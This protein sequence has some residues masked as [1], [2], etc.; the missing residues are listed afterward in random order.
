VYVYISDLFKRK[1]RLYICERT[2]DEYDITRI[3][4]DITGRGDIGGYL[5]DT[6]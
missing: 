1:T 2:K 3:K 5:D 4:N 6:L